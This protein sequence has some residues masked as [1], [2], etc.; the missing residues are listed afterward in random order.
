MSCAAL[1][2]LVV[3]TAATAGAPRELFR[4]ALLTPHGHR[5]GT[6]LHPF[7]PRS[8]VAKWYPDNYGMG[9]GEVFRIVV[10]DVRGK[11]IVVYLENA[12]LPA[13][14]FPDFLTR[15]DTLL[16]TLRFPK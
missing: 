2:N 5:E 4:N 14:E 9:Q 13:D 12:K 7:S 15:A 6:R 16:K 8:T 11:T 1:E 3:I 10:L